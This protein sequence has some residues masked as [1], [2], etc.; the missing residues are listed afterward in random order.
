[1]KQNN[2]F[3]PDVLFEQMTAISKAAA[4]DA[5]L[6][7]YQEMQETI[8]KL[9]WERDV[10]KIKLKAESALLEAYKAFVNEIRPK[11]AEV[12]PLGEVD[13]EIE[14]ELNN[15]DDIKNVL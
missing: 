7:K 10:L 2:I 6:P 4:Y 3:N 13:Q 9:E 14:N 1:M 15:R 11:D 8:A 12:I 5:I